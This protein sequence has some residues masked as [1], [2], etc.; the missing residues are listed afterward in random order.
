MS[1][2]ENGPP[3]SRTRAFLP[4]GPTV[5]AYDLWQ[6]HKRKQE[7]REEHLDY[8][9]ASS[10]DTGTGRPVDAIICPAAAYAAPPHGK[11]T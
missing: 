10:K 2:D 8:W 9:A 7:L 11:N 4:P 3:S 1:L 6:V 5:T